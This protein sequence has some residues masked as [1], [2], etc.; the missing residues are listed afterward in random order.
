MKTSQNT[1]MTQSQAF[2]LVKRLWKE[3]L[4]RDDLKATIREPTHLLFD[5]EKAGNFQFLAELTSSYPGLIWE[6][7]G[8]KQNIF[9]IAVLHRHA[10]IFNL[11]YELGSMKDVI[12]AYKDHMGNNMLHLMAKLPDQNRLKMVSVAALQMQ[13]ESVWFNRS[14][15]KV[16]AISDADDRP[17]YAFHLYDKHD[18]SL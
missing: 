1:T 18:G 9:H 16:F 10:S 3:V 7:D 2:Q 17:L 14:A 15:F 8:K 12:T 13:R 6:T 5:A 4:K 11:I